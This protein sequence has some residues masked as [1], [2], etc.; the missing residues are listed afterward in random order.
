MTEFL[1]RTPAKLGDA[2]EKFNGFID[3]KITSYPEDQPRL[4]EIKSKFNGWVER[5]RQMTLL[6]TLLSASPSELA[7]HHFFEGVD[8][9]MEH[10]IQRFKLFI[11]VRL[12]LP[13]VPGE[14]LR[15]ILDRF[16]KLAMTVL[17][18]RLIAK[19]KTSPGVEFVATFLRVGKSLA[20]DPVDTFQKFVKREVRRN[21]KDRKDWKR[22]TTHFEKS[23]R[24]IQAM[25]SLAVELQRGRMM[26]V[27]T[28]FFSDARAIG[29]DP[30]AVFYSCVDSQI[31]QNPVQAEAWRLIKANF[32][33]WATMDL[34]M[35]ELEFN[36]ALAPDVAA[37]DSFLTATKRLSDNPMRV[38][39]MFLTEKIRSDPYRAVGISQVLIHFE[40]SALAVLMDRLEWDLKTP[41]SQPQRI[42]QFVATAKSV[43][44]APLA[45][46]KVFSKSDV[47]PV[48][49]WQRQVD[50]GMTTLLETFKPDP[51]SKADFRHNLA[52]AEE[53]LR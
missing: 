42:G 47:T 9:T 2:V 27:T 17:L 19:L 41:R 44:S 49:A 35:T 32:E 18:G 53:F 50:Q 22:V 3:D 25:N 21:V 40:Q 29:V 43:S 15:G 12:G 13:P 31:G 4:V 33:Q 5:H 10:S 8:A 20:V 1:I 23:W 45:E 26:N 52:C 30:R 36:L 48:D 24:L 39:K 6:M 14:N 37:V 51:L 38:F 16:D 11:D 28:S 34:H 46:F 7:V